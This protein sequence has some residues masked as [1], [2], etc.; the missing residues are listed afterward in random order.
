[1]ISRTTL[2]L[3]VAVLATGPAFAASE[4]PK[5]APSSEGEAKKA[6]PEPGPV[7]G[8]PQLTTATFGDWVERCQRVN[9]AGESRRMCEVA[10]TVTAS[11]QS[12]PLA[13]I[14]IGRAKKSDPLH[15]T[16]V[17]PVNVAFPSAPKISLGDDSEP[18]ELAW[19]NCLPAGCFADGAFAADTQ[20][21]W[22]EGKQAKVESKAAG[23]QAF[24]FA[25][26]LRG[27]PQALD[28]M[29]REIDR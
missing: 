1:M 9:A 22:R 3:A 15:L 23:G 6:N 26:S 24:N 4:K 12:Q 11:G 13:E 2:F 7:S 5:P 21:A 16:L 10:T 18:L 29:A 14:A 20:R 8:D 25:V 28:A 17:L 27:L 19:R